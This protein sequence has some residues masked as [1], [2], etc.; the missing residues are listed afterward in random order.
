MI[1][2]LIAKTKK[3]KESMRKSNSLLMVP[4]WTAVGIVLTTWS[5]LLRRH[6]VTSTKLFLEWLDTESLDT[7]AVCNDGS[8]GAFYFAP[9]TDSAMVNDFLIYLP[10]GG[11][12]YDE[13]SCSQRWKE[14]GS[15]YMSSK[16][17]AIELEKDGILSDDP[18]VSPW[19]GANK[20]VL[21]YCSSDGYMGD[22]GAS[23][24][25]WQWHFRGQRLV[26][27]MIQQ[28][29]RDKGLSSRS[30]ILMGGSS[31]GGR[32]VMTNAESLFG[33]SSLASSWL[34]RGSTAAL[35]LDS[36]YYIDIQPYTPA[37]VG[38]A[39]EEQSKYAVMQ[40]QRALSRS[41]AK[42]YPQAE[43]WKCQFGEYR[44]PFVSMDEYPFL[45]IASQYDAYQ[46]GCNTQRTPP[47]SLYPAD[48]DALTDYASAFAFHTKD[49]LQ[50]WIAASNEA[51]S[52]D[53][54]KVAAQKAVLSW[55]CYNHAIADT[56]G[57]ATVTTSSGISQRDALIAWLATNPFVTVPMTRSQ[58]LQEAEAIEEEEEEE[59]E[60][61]AVVVEEEE[62]GEE[63]K[64]VLVWM[65][66]CVGFACG[67][68]CQ[69]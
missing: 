58:G 68:G 1:S 4:S 25:T 20:A 62:V 45:L 64:R 19:W 39:Y 2:L 32:G 63:A 52:D 37:F 17:L 67:T 22:A 23:K 59:E 26:K 61:K 21:A 50:Q 42:A 33:S 3:R 49:A 27:T 41:C 35:F 60:D 11:Q 53:G 14:I 69:A 40:T 57:F 24:T 65:D 56:T 30:R 36:P 38:F 12:C 29:I 55:A 54:G 28:L 5:V 15:T 31:A 43:R 34:P 44:I 13:T 9:A 16:G 6:S 8:P 66:D 48:S 7:Q 47:Y 18:S 51:A 46:L 10:G